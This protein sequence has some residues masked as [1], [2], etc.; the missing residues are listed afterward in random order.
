MK[1]RIVIAIFSITVLFVSC[2]KGHEKGVIEADISK[3]T[4]DFDQVIVDMRGFQ[5]LGDSTVIRDTVKAVDGKFKY[6]F[7][8]KEAKLTHF[9]LLKKGKIVGFLDFI[10]KFKPKSLYGNLYVGNER[11]QINTDRYYYK[12]ENIMGGKKHYIVNYEGSRETDMLY[13]VDEKKITTNLIKENPNSF[14]LLHQLFWK[15]DEFSIK[16]LKQFSELFCDELKRSTSYSMLMKDITKKEHFALYGYKPN[17]KWTDVA[18]QSYTFDQAINKRKYMLLVFW[19]SW[20]GPCR[21]EIPEL[22]KFQEE[23]GK[24]I[25]LV[26]LSIDDNFNSWKK[27]LEKEKMTWLNLSGLPNNPLAIKQEYNISAVPSL[28]LLDNSGKVLV[29]NVNNLNEIKTFVSKNE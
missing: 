11:L 5:L 18:N 16:E 29:S 6:Q 2:N 22:K 25:S 1:R 4:K 28:I 21:Q 23:Y 8:I 14:T 17:F 20:C 19:A 7:Q 10:N 27:A 13:F 15:K 3:I 24:K 9:A 26:S 12:K